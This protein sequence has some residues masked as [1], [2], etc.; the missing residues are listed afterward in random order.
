MPTASLDED[1]R[2]IA[3]SGQVELAKKL[4]RKRDKRAEISDRLLDPRTR[5]IGASVTKWQ[6]QIAEKEEFRQ[7]QIHAAREDRAVL[8]ELDRISQQIEREHR[9]ATREREKLAR[10][11][12]LENLSKTARREYYLSDPK[13]DLSIDM[14]H[15]GPS[16]AQVFAGEFVEDKKATQSEIVRGLKEQELEKEVL[17]QR[18]AA[19]ERAFAELSDLDVKT[20]IELENREEDSI[21][22]GRRALDEFNCEMQ[23]KRKEK[24]RRER[25]D[26]ETR[27]KRD[28]DF[29]LYQ[30]YLLTDREAI[31]SVGRSGLLN[32]GIGTSSDFKGIPLD[33]KQMIM[34]WQARQVDEKRERIADENDRRARD[35]AE[36][37]AQRLEAVKVH[38]EQELQRR[39]AAQA[40]VEENRR[41][42]EAQNKER[43]RTE[44]VYSSSIKETFFDQF[45][46][47]ACH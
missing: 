20:R 34:D 39:R 7:S 26:A 43:I 44:K 14:E 12:S 35:A 29:H 1:L 37:E 24:E 5:Q 18:E 40:L 13:R 30:R 36:T 17:L 45:A 31:V 3:E 33:E 25:E 2:E 21:R 15:L 6:K 19:L 23:Q 11:H 38:D 10:Y 9:E 47:S 4:Q 22:A 27:A 41:L 16:A 42:A 8:E 32:E 46:K 28:V